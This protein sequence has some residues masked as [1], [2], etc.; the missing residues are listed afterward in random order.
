MKNLNLLSILAVALMT[1]LSTTVSAQTE[2]SDSKEATASAVLVTPLELTLGDNLHF[3]AIIKP[4]TIGGTVELST[5]GTPSPS[6]DL[7]MSGIDSPTAGKFT[8]TGTPES[9]F[10]MTFP[11]EIT[12]DFDGN[13]T[14]G[15]GMPTSMTIDNLKVT[16]ASQGIAP[17]EGTP[18]PNYQAVIEHDITTQGENITNIN[19]GV[20][21]SRSVNIGG[22]LNIA[23]NQMTGPYSGQYTVSVDYN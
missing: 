4:A 20:N 7:V 9:L 11:N 19:L 8:V 15:I 17:V 2:S 6:D 1:G 16:I 22:T 23:V 18:S 5:D 13:A 21:G 12:V 3:G 14:P 10:T